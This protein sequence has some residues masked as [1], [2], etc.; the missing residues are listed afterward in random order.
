MIAATSARQRTLK[1]RPVKKPKKTRS[2]EDKREKRRQTIAKIIKDNEKK[3]AYEAAEHAT[4][5]VELE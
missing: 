2:R 3:G 4:S 5:E 1:E